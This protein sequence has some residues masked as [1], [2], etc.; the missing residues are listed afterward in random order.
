MPLTFSAGYGWETWKRSEARN[1]ADLREGSP[2]FSLDVGV[3][4][5]MSLRSSYTTGRRRI[6][7]EYIQNTTDDQPLHRRFDQA[8]RDRERTNLLATVTPLDQLTMSG[9]WTVGHDEYPHSAYGLQSDR[10][11]MQEGDISWALTDRFSVDGSLTNERFLTRLR[12]QYRANGRLNNPTYDWVANNHDEIRTVSAGFRAAFVPDRFEAGGRLDAS[13]AKF[14]MAT[15]NPLTP[16]GG[17]ATQN[18]A[19]TASDLPLV[20]QKFQPMMLFATYF[21]TPEWEMTFR[22]ETERWAQNDFRTLGLQPSTGN[23]IFLGNNLNDYNARFITISISY[24]PR[25]RR[26]ARPAL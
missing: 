22:Y 3:F 20:T 19:A 17:T 1:V 6:H 8:D 16:T 13:R 10:N 12:S 21:V 14:R 2:H 15:F 5:W 4:D 11:N 18:F 25:L 24:R 7:G 9:S 23:A 26:V